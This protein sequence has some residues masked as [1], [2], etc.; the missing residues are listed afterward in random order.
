MYIFYS[1]FLVTLLLPV[2]LSYLFDISLSKI[3]VNLISY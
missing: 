3:F 1:G 2:N